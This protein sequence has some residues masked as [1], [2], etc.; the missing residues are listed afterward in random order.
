MAQTYLGQ[1]RLRKYYGKISEVLEMPNLIE[2][3]KSSY[4]LFLNSGDGPAPADGEGIQGVFQ[5]V[6]PIKDFNETSV[7][8]FVKYELEKPKYDVDECMQRDMTYAA[9]LKVTLRLI[10]FDIDE[11][12]G[13]KSVKDIKEQDVFMGD[14]PLMTPNGTFIVNGTERVIVS[15]M[16]RS[17]G[18]FF[19][20]DKGKT[21]SSGKLLF[22]CRIIPYRGSW[23]DFE[24][25]AKDIVFARIDRRRKLPVT[26]LLYALGLDQEGIMDAYY[27]T[28][29]FRL[30]KNRGWVTRFFPERVRG[31]RPTYDLVDAATGEVI[32]K[33]GDKVTPRQVKKL[34]EEGKVTELL[35]PFDQI[36]GRYVAKDI[37][38]EETGAIYVE[39][40][41]ELTWDLDRDGEVSGGTLK[42]LLD[43]GI[44]EIPVLDIDNINVGPY[45]RN[46]MAAD[47]NMGRDTALMD[48]YRVMRPGEPPTVEAATNLF[49]TLFFDAERYDLS[50]V[51]RVKMNMRLALDA[52]DTQRTLRRDDI[53]ACIK[54]LVELRD[55]KGEIDDIDHLGN[56]RVRSVGELMENQYRV[57]LLRMERAIKERMSSVEIDTVMPQDLINAKPAA[58]AVR[59]FFGSSQLSQ[60]MDQTNPLSEVTHKRRLSALGPGGL[61][62]ERAGFEVRDV[63]PTHYGRMCPIETPEGPNIGLINSLATFARV[64]KYGF[65]ET[66]YRKVVDGQVTDEVNYMSATEE[67]RHTVAQANANLDE[68]GR[69]VNDLVNTRQSGEYTMAP[70]ES[71][72]LIDVSPKQLVSVAASLIPFLENDDANRA[73]MG[74]NMQRQALPLIQ[75]EAPFVGTG[76]ERKVA[77]DSGAAIQARRAG[78]IDQV[79]AQRI[80]VRA[81][82][83]LE[84]GDAGVDIY[85]LRKF[86]RSNQNSCINQRPLVK[87]GDTVTKGE[88]IADGPCTDMGELAVGRNVIVAFM[89]WNGYNYE[90]SILISE[91]IARDDVFTSIHIEEFEVAARDTKLG[92]EEITRDIPN[93]GEE[94]LRNLDEA[95]IVYIGAEVGPGDIL[96]GKITPK[97]ESPMTPEEKLLRAIFGEKASDVRDT[98]LRLPPGDYGTVVEVRVFNRHGVDKDERALQIEREAVESLARDRD[99]ELA[100]LERNI[101]ARLKSMI[102]DKVAVK[103][104]KGVPANAQITEDL[105]ASLSRGQWW[106]L[107]LEG[108]QDAAEVEALNAQFEA[109]RRALDHRFEDKVEKVRRGDDLPP[110]VMKMVKVFIAVKR[111]LQPGDKMAGRHGNK[112]VVSKVVP[113][114]DMPFLADGTP[115][116]IVLNP[117]GV[118]SRMN[119]GQ[120]LETHMGWA[121]RGLGIKIDDALGEYRRTGDLTPVREAMRLAYGDDVYEEG[122]RD[123]DEGTLIE[124]AATVTRGVPIATPVF[125]GAKE[126]DVNDALKRAGF[127]TSG[128]SVLFDGRTGER[129]ARPV[130]VGVKYILKLH[131]LVDDKIHARSTGPYSLVTQQPLG[132]KA[133]FGGQRFGEMEVWALEAYGAAYTLQEM[134]TVKSD[135][136]AGRTKVYE[137]IVKGEDNFEAGVPESF[138]VLVKEV[139]GLG[140]NMELL[141]AEEDE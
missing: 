47:K 89:P 59:E 36:V 31:T 25:D 124:A 37:I 12:T 127:D 39:A 9:P 118:P 102:L 19:D 111:K 133:Q 38:N 22:A 115:V 17:P 126:A 134:L 120:I 27:D 106:Q 139:R 97:G 138:N 130:T 61:T 20:H 79:D 132:G 91:R 116:D 92:P 86:Q 16:H 128:Q 82:E 43:A 35:V 73:L 64:N 55:G 129:F 6:F 113:M 13:A 48:I 1:K 67:M 96:V 49:E 84:L 7:L 54:A 24:F 50:A 40:G 83:D 5:S 87:V 66:P 32:C 41:D 93:V 29:Q 44:T 30:E 56:R 70:R 98:S 101:Y 95:G 15:Q 109:Q 136:V 23:L 107:A 46:T 112:G 75:A 60:F 121:A 63:H 8:E 72:D 28:V 100:I 104:P 33:A 90:D 52:P 45:I 58:A 11:D 14:M 34:I 88:V 53:I 10:V 69:F 114:E 108:E 2:V 51:G 42:A 3:Q 85:R 117:L 125:D 135:D 68:Q 80:V 21:H 81:T 123:M 141:D 62:R 65:I 76:M 18:V 105:L 4:D 122:I 137:S 57:G 103:G 26:T 110:G 140:L 74:S 77:I 94:A 131:H 71:V 78:V 119:V 99:D